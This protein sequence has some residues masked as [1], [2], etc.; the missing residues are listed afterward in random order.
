MN[1]DADFARRMED[2][3]RRKDKERKERLREQRI[4]DAKR[5]DDINRRRKQ[6]NDTNSGC[7]LT[8]IFVSAAAGVLL[9]V[10]AKV[11]L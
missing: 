10:L 6:I 9:G 5:E 1:N 8:I 7:A 11:I 3:A 4:R 2:A